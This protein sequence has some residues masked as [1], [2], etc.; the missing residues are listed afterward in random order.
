[1]LCVVCVVDRAML[2]G[3]PVTFEVDFV[4]PNNKRE[5]GR[6]FLGDDNVGLTVVGQGW[7]KLS[8]GARDRAVYRQY[9]GAL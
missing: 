5:Y 3:K 8:P 4:N 7:G 9:S 1:V 6:V 2:I